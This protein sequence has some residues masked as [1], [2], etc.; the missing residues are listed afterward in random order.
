[1]RL[2]GEELAYTTKRG[3][4]FA[5]KGSGVEITFTTGEKRFMVNAKLP[6]EKDTEAQNHLIG[7]AGGPIAYR[8][9][10]TGGHPR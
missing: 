2:K 6:D 10:L 5:A 4:R 1:M 3:V 9:G 7:N 8:N